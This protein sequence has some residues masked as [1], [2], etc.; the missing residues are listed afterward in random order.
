[1]RDL[2][3]MQPG[4]DRDHAEP[5]GPAGEQHFQELGAVF[6]AQHDAVAGL[7]TTRDQPGR[8]ARDPAGEFGIAPGVDAVADCR[9]LRLAAGDVKQICREVQLSPLR[10][11]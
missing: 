6:H 11:L 2:L 8:Q 7:E 10:V 4:V 1:M 3:G 5:G 9:P